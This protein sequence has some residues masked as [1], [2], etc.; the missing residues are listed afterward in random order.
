[1]SCG[2]YAFLFKKMEYHCGRLGD[3]CLIHERFQDKKKGLNAVKN[4]MENDA[5]QQIVGFDT[6]RG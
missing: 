3:I 5:R 1:M 4:G 6:Y 2:S